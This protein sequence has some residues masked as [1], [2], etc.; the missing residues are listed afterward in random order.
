MACGD[1]A[2]PGPGNHRGVIGAKAWRRRMERIA[3]RLAFA[4]ERISQGPVC[5]D[6][7]CGH[8]PFRQAFRIVEPEG[9]AEPV[10]KRFSRGSLEGGA[11]VRDI[12]AAERRMGQRG[13]A[14]GCF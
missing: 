7:P 1:A 4:E 14:N 3:E 2:G 12:L 11:E 8:K 5:G 9:G 10:S 13:V 6:A